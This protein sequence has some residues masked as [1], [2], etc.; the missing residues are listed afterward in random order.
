MKF[1]KDVLQNERVRIET[2]LKEQGYYR[3]SKE[4]VYF[5]ANTF[6]DE[7][8]VDLVLGLKEYIEGSPDPRSKVKH[9]PS[10]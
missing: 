9:H 7:K 1:D 8:S 5:Q 4:Y 3:F 2:L 10:I 6:P